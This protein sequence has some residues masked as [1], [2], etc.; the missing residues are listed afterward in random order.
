MYKTTNNDQ[1]E[2]K[3]SY[4]ELKR[5]IIIIGISNIGSKAI[6]FLLAPLYSYYLSTTQYGQMDLITT[7]TNLLVP[8]ICLDLFE[9]AFRFCSDN[10]LDKKVVISTCLTTCI[11]SF[12]ILLIVLIITLHIAKT[13]K[14]IIYTC[15]FL[16]LDSINQILQQYL[17]GI[18]KL[19]AFALSGVINSITLL[20]FN[21]IFLI[22]L[23]LELDG[24]LISYLFGK[25]A[26]LIYTAKN[27]DL[28]DNY[29]IYYFDKK[30]LQELLEYCIPLLPTQ[31]MWWIMNA[32][33]RYM[34]ALYINTSINGIYAV[35]NKLPSL[36]S[37]FENIFYQSFQIVGVK[38]ANNKENNELYSNIFNSYLNVL[39]IG[40]LAILIFLKQI[41]ILIF[42]KEYC[43]AWMPSAILLIA[44][45][46]H[47]LS[48]NIGIYYTVFKK[49][50]GALVT[51]SIGA[52]TNIILNTIFI[53]KYSIMAAATTTLIGYLV[54]LFI[55][56]FDIKRMITIKLNYKNAI[57]CTFSIIMQLIL[58]Y[59]PGKISILSRCIIFT[60]IL[61]RKR[62]IIIKI[63]KR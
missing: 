27:C 38:D 49:T 36:L 7:T 4:R 63:I 19:N 54:T 17:R 28:K 5:N 18:G 6:A 32:S 11:P 48:G 60:I 50:K 45:L 40:I 58:Y 37:I 47:A 13:P 8:I 29:S 2:I 31:I 22:L 52:I 44:V 25:I 46:I 20:V 57:I 56:W 9:A 35:A 53:P 12:F 14:L 3:E 39:T 43:S 23:K 1:M 61:Y 24:W 55:R 51:S 42:D 15:I 62:N 21:F 34:L 41:T 33:D 30:L 16:I 10:E 26:V 59:I